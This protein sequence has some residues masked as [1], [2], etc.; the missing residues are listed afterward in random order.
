MQ[1]IVKNITIKA[2]IDH[3]WRYLSEQDKFEAWMLTMSGAPRLNETFYFRMTPQAD[4]NW[5][6]EIRCVVTRMEAPHTLEFSWSHNEIDFVDTKVAIS[7]KE[8]EGGTEVTLIHSAW[9]AVQDETVRSKQ[10]ADHNE[11]WDE[12]LTIWSELASGQSDQGWMA[13]GGHCS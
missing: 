4:S 3:V 2:P 7:L 12:H 13:R 8:V 1:D 5:D 6:G 9:D 11:G 10:F